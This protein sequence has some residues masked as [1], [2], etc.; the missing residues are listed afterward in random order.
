ML[1]HPL[2]SAACRR[3]R[4]SPRRR[5][6]QPQLDAVRAAISSPQVAA[7]LQRY[8]KAVRCGTAPPSCRCCLAAP[9]QRR[10]TAGTA[11]RVTPAWHAASCE[12]ALISRTHHA[13]TLGG[14]AG[15]YGTA[16]GGAGPPRP[17]VLA[18]AGAG[19]WAV[20][21]ARYHA[22]TAP[23]P[24]LLHAEV[25]L[26]CGCGRRLGG[27]L[28]A[29]A[30]AARLCSQ[31][32]AAAPLPAPCLPQIPRPVGAPRMIQPSPQMR[33]QVG[34]ARCTQGCD[35]LEGAPGL[36]HARRTATRRSSCIACTQIIH[37]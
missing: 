5:R 37:R 10:P 1:P 13:P 3:R 30:G 18:E 26:R 20:P 25:C 17:D 27:A 23:V 15:L 12:C 31:G 36:R 33:Q 2:T 8:Q 32:A 4:S 29:G 6:R 22:G 34:T 16:G 24:P 35:E 9:A 19:W 28:H 21:P 14:T 11:S 7:E